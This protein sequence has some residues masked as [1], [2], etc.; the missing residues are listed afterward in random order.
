ML[1]I[2]A[3]SVYGAVLRQIELTEFFIQGLLRADLGRKKGWIFEIF[4]VL[5]LVSTDFMNKQ[6]WSSEIFESFLHY[7]QT[8]K[9]VCPEIQDTLN[10]KAITIFQPFGTKFPF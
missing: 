3:S 4:S 5:M 8:I 9:K 7:R 2:F 10:I 6:G 1:F